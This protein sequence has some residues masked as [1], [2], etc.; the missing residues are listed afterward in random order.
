M[1]MYNAIINAVQTKVSYTV[2][3]NGTAIQN[4]RTSLLGDTLTLDGHHLDLKI[5]RFIAGLT[6]ALKVT[7]EDIANLTYAPGGINDT[8]LA[9]ILESVQ[10]ALATPFAVTQSE[11]EEDIV[12]ENPDVVAGGSNA[13][14][15]KIYKGDATELGFAKDTIVYQYVGVD[16][17]NDKAAIKVDSSSYDYVEVQLIIAEGDGYFFLYGLKGGNYHK[18]GTSYVVD[19]SWLRFGNGEESD[20]VIEVFDAAG[21]KVTSLMKNNVIYTLRVYIKVGELD[22]IRIGKNGSTIYFA[23]VKQGLESDLDTPVTDENPVINYKG[24]VLNRYKGDETALGFAKDTIVYEYVMDNRTD[25]WKPGTNLGLTM[26]QQTIKLSKAT[27]EDYA[28]IFFSLSREITNPT[29][30]FFSWWYDASGKLASSTVGYLHIDGSFTDTS[31]GTIVGAKAAFFDKD[32]NKVTSLSAN[33]VYEMR[34]Y[35]EGV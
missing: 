11:I 25:N 28:S 20:R 27:D 19:P 31:D 16:T 32:G 13:T 7:G 1:T 15:V 18:G 35:G 23:N 9:I 8:Q 10:N 34:W 2:I 6:F 5:G 14:A 12:I 21:N 3:P 29:Y 24:E 4:A 26:E 22:E 33:T 30:A 17:S